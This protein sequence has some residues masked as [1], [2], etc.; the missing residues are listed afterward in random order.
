MKYL[1][2]T[3]PLAAVLMG[4]GS[5]GADTNTANATGDNSATSSTAEV[6]QVQYTQNSDNAPPTAN[7]SATDS[8][9]GNPVNAGTNKSSI[10][11]KSADGTTERDDQYRV[12]D[13]AGPGMPPEVV[14]ALNKVKV[15]PPPKSMKTPSKATLRLDTSKGAITVELN[16]KEAPL[17][18]KSFIY[19][20]KSGF[21]NGTVWHRY[22]PGFVIQ[23]GDPL[24]KFP[25]LSKRFYGTGGPGYQVPREYNKLKHDQYVLA[26]AR[27]EDP[28]SAGSQFYFTLE[29][30]H[31]LDDGYTVFGKVVS[32]QKAVA[33][34]RE[35]DKLTSIK[36]LSE[37][38]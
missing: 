30:S 36:V 5:S 17:H 6:G 18:V 10:V 13:E 15:P 38:P 11:K 24:T 37:T 2:T 34:L 21:Y 8:A 26:M 25:K 20:A 32:G 7:G 29:P 22:E 4:C 9:T 14:A 28:D 16:G 33:A 23:G 12:I 3:L 1:L 31:F 27:S 35:G 19:L